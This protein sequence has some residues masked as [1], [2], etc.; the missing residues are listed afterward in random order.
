MATTSVAFSN[1]P[2]ASPTVSVNPELT[3]SNHKTIIT[4]TLNESIR[5]QLRRSQTDEGNKRNKNDSPHPNTTSNQMQQSIFAA[6]KEVEQ[7]AI[8]AK[9]AKYPTAS[10]GRRRERTYS[11]LGSYRRASGYRSA[12][13]SPQRSR[14]IVLAVSKEAY[15]HYLHQLLQKSAVQN[16]QDARS[17]LERQVEELKGC[18]ES[19]LSEHQQKMYRWI[20]KLVMQDQRVNILILNK[21]KDLESELS[22]A[23]L[24]SSSFTG[25]RKAAEDGEP[26]AQFTLGMCYYEGK[27]VEQDW[28]QAIIW[29]QKAA[30]QGQLEAQYNLGLCY[31]NGQGVSKDKG[32]ACE[33]FALSADQGL[34]E[35]LL[36]LGIIAYDDKD[37]QSAFLLFEKA[38]QHG[39]AQAQYNLGVCYFEGIGVKKNKTRA[40]FWFQQA[41]AKGLEKAEEVLKGIAEALS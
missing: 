39:C 23:T 24:P 19:E 9:L 3:Q 28:D 11:E 18:K 41:A 40:I 6:Q 12:S 22:L 27:D 2:G 8:N 21:L 33:Y 4:Y 38:A 35:A 20:Q 34:P 16:N 5:P 36:S 17:L 14:E 1:G 7:V 32:K 13:R 26:S 30:S 25:C 31:Y 29:F 15:R 37:S 10:K